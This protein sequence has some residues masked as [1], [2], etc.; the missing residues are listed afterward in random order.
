LLKPQKS[1]QKTF[2]LNCI[3]SKKY[4]L[5]LNSLYNV[6]VNDEFKQDFEIHRGKK[7]SQWSLISNILNVFIF[8]LILYQRKNK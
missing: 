4:P 2:N 7:Y 8:G 5:V 6:D 1:W 3:E